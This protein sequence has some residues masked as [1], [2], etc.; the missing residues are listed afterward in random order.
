MGAAWRS[1]RDGRD[2]D[3]VVHLV[4]AVHAEGLEVCCTLGMLTEAQARRLKDAGLYAY[5]HNIDTSREF[6]DQIIQTRTYDDRLETIRN[7]RA[8]GLTV[9]TGGILGMG[10]SG[11]DRRAFIHQLVSFDPVPESITINSLV[12]FDGTPLEKR[13]PIDPLEIVRVIAT[14]R[15]LAP[16]AMIRLSAGRLEMSAEA[17]FLSFLCG[18]NSIF[19]GDKLLTSPNPDVAR[20]R[21]D[22]ARM[23]FTLMRAGAASPETSRA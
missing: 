20:D 16:R 1:V 23:G 8:A 4:E 14:I 9:C 19:L 5:N 6:Y 22:L 13:A 3:H 10:E 17:Q 15:V 18:A 21:E 11:A 2:F 12:S 7:V